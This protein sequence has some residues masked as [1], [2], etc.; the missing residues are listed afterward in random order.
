M[1]IDQIKRIPI[2]QVL[3]IHGIKPARTYVNRWTYHAINRTDK[4]PSM[5]V[6][7]RKNLFKD[8]GSDARGSVIDLVMLLKGYRV[9][10][11]IEYLVAFDGVNFEEK[12][13]ER[14]EH[15]LIEPSIV[16]N[17]VLPL[18]HPALLQYAKS[19]GIDNRLISK[20]CQQVHYSTGDR[21][22]F[23]I[24]FQNEKGGF[25]LRS[26][27]F[28]GCTSKWYSHIM[29]GGDN[30]LVFEGFFNFTALLSVNQKARRGHD[31]LVLNST[32]LKEKFP[33]EILK[34][35]SQIFLF[36]DNDA[37]GKKAT[38]YFVSLLQNATDCSSLYEP[39]NDVNDWLMSKK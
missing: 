7:L 11:A 22:Y 14:P 38:N 30:L 26:K 20:Y 1:D 24:G 36:L 16:I 5:S 2:I 35:Y 34:E 23:A 6:D 12:K 19:R 31:Y 4:D 15:L 32:S 10:E 37:T 13:N 39:F 21:S 29:N 25:E 9:K 3:E 17:K 27:M 18:T 8:F 28:K 33:L